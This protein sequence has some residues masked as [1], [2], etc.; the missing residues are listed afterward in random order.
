MKKELDFYGDIRTPDIRMLRDMDHVV[1]DQKWLESVENFELYYMYRDLYKSEADSNAIKAHNLRYDITIIPP[2]M[3][4][5]EFIK[6][7]GHYHPHVPGTDISYTEVYQ[8]LEGEAT[9]I[10]Q[11]EE[12]GKITDVM[13]YKVKKGGFVVIPP[14]YG[15]M[16]INASNETLKM[17][18]W[19]C[20][21]FSSIYDEIRN[22]SGGAY[23]LLEEGFVPNPEYVDAPEIRFMESQ[24]DSE[25]GLFD[26]SDMYDLVN[27]LDKLKFLTRPQDYLHIFEKIIA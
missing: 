25:L 11:K 16:T 6:T 5:K 24:D 8:V 18:N 13:V 14:N 10:L 3:L 2:A 1:F 19:V 12:H 9:Y 17:A 15:H 21:D 26:G 4:G 23:Y 7:A 27:D 20:R 22:M